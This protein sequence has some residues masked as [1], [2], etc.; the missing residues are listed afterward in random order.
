MLPSSSTGGDGFMQRLYQ[1]SMAIVR[2]FGKPSLFITF[3]TNPYWIEITREFLMDENSIV[4]QTC[5]D[6]PDLRESFL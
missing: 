6:C 2:H 5:R 3:T 4:M 1:D